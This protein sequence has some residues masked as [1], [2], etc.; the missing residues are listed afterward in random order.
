MARQF[1]KEFGALTGGE[2]SLSAPRVLAIRKAQ[3]LSQA[4]F[5]ELLNVLALSERQWARGAKVPS[6]ASLR[7]LQLVETNRIE[8]VLQL[9]A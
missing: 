4:A 7:R 6:G 3:R 9:S 2:R 8:M 1:E 5:A